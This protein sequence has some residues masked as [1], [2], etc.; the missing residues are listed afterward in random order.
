MRFL[1]SHNNYPAQFRRLIP[2]L[3]A[4]GHEVV[5]LCRNKEWH[6]PDVQGVRLIKFEPHRAGGGA[7][8][9]PYLRRFEEAVLQ[10]QAAY[11]ALHPLVQSGWVPDWIIT[12]VGFGN[13][14]YLNDV[15]PTARRIGLFEWY[16]NAVGTDADFLRQ[17]PVDPDQK[18]KLRTWNAHL[19]LEL[20]ACDHAITPTRWQRHQFPKAMRRQLQ[21]IHEGIDWPLMASLRTS[22]MPR[23]VCLP[24]DPDLEVVTYVSRGFEEYRGFP[25][26]MQVIAQLQRQRPNLHAVIV[27]HDTVAYGDKRSDGRSWGQ[28]AKSEVPLDQARTHWLGI[29]QDAE[30]QQVLACS[31]VHL[32]LTVPFVLSW[33]LLE[34]MAAGCALVAS[35]TAPVQEV[36]ED[37]ES[38][39]LVDFFDVEAQVAALNRLLDNPSLRQGLATSAQQKAS[40]YTSSIGLSAWAGV[41]GLELGT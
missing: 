12:H 8:I 25:Q 31:T 33:S 26:A 24:P 1:F 19:L 3:V 13:G 5:F 14:L 36:L 37:G 40:D 4:S 16:Y 27:G 15:F 7:Q 28:W 17:G 35:A 21:V 6:A 34:A 10:G 29:L 38:A 32:Y 20:A 11:R 2:A 22:G 41:F 39:L 23:P 30:Y 18:L 9:H